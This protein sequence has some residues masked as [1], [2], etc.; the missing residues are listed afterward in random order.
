M[1]LSIFSFDGSRHQQ[2]N[3]MLFPFAAEGLTKREAA[4][5]LLNRFT[6]GPTPGAVDSVMEMGLENWFLSQVQGNLPDDDL[7]EKLNS[8]DA[9]KMSN[10]EISAIF[11]NRA[12]L[13]KRAR[14]EGIVKEKDTV[15]GKR[16][17]YRKELADFMEK[18]GYR[19][20]QELMGQ[21][22]SRKIWSATYSK[23]QLHQVLI[24]FWFN[25]FNVSATKIQL[26]PF[27]ANY[28]R[29]AI[30]PN[31]TGKFESL[32]SA[33]AHS[34]AMQL[35]LDNFIS[36]A[37][38]DSMETRMPF[39]KN[40]KQNKRGINEN[41]AREIMELHTL[42]VDGGYTQED[43]TNAAR[44]FTG[45]TI[46]PLRNDQ[47]SY[48]EKIIDRFGME[49]LIAKGFVIKDDFLF[50][51]NRHDTKEK[52]VLGQKFPSNG[53]YQEGVTLIKLLAHHPATAKFI[54]K[55]IAV[56]FV[57][58]H[59]SN[60]L[61]DKMSATFINTDGA[62]S[63]VLKTMVTSR[64]FWKKEVIA[65]KTKSPLELAISSAR[66]VNADIEDP[67]MLYQWITKMGQRLYYYQAPNGF[68]DK[69]EQ[70]INTGSL[71][72]RMNF[73]LLFAAQKIP[74][75]DFN[76]IALNNY[77]EPESMSEALQLYSK[78]CLPE[79][80]LEA[81]IH[82][83][84]P[85]VADPTIGQKVNDLAT[86]NSD[87]ESEMNMSSAQDDFAIDVKNEKE[88]KM[89]QRVEKKMLSKK[90]IRKEMRTPTMEGDNSMLAQIVGII[91][92][93]PEFQRR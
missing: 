47:E 33:T 89:Q 21:L 8:L 77:H 64:E 23:N 50:N 85:L 87:T 56:R 73:G 65:S 69:S 18:N 19:P 67:L 15:K 55:K 25:H 9:L 24:D 31:V 37:E 88:D 34:R 60:D 80:P 11:P 14:E 52:I 93:S 6:Y 5:H 54:C 53:G 42:G 3:Q 63:E 48:F 81:T 72:N 59:P 40:A 35:Y 86:K 70:W 68:P 74:G 29:D 10:K 49:N 7:N 16:F 39:N 78:I 27:I 90:G 26:A 61:L 66:A 20:Q 83:L 1:L 46:F 30:D 58:D 13:T 4:A 32:L 41:Y 71:L 84:T 51:I 91:I 57:S 75:I 17:E 92:G 76:L 79:R 36:A 28:E 43:V 82:R 12:F 38:I 2:Q 62:I 45:W 22:I 44:V